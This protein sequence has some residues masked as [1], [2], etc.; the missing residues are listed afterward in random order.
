[1]DRNQRDIKYFNEK[2][3]NTF[4]VKPFTE[5]ATTP[6]G[7]VKLCC[8][9]EGIDTT[10]DPY[11]TK[12]FQEVFD[13]STQLIQARKDL[14]S[15]KKIKECNACW[16]D[17]A[18]GNMSMRIEHS[19]YLEETNPTIL[20]NIRDFGKTEVKSIDIKFGNKCNYACVMCAPDNS[21]LWGKEIDKNP[22]PEGL[23]PSGFSTALIE[24]PNDKYDEL[25]EI[26]KN[27]VRI[28]ST[29]GEPMLLDGFKTYIKKLVESGYAKNIVFTTVTNGTIDCTD[30]LPYMNQFKKFNMQWSVDGTGRVYDY[31]RWPGNFDRMRRIHEKLAVEIKKNNYNRIKI[32]MLPVIQLFNLQ[33]LGDMIQ[34]AEEIGIVDTVEFS[35][36]FHEPE[37][38]NTGVLPNDMFENILAKLDEQ[39]KPFKVNHSYENIK[40]ILQKEQ[41]RIK[42]KKELFQRT[43]KM[44]SWWE[45]TRKINIYDHI[46]TYKD[47]EKQY[48]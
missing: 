21:S 45:K 36:I 20:E 19:R 3:G 33:N 34:Y 14:L 17:E 22:L 11:F 4:C 46:E 2:Y 1:M 9:S 5:I 26:S 37:Y 43:K 7:G 30:L 42:N 13:S 41:R 28:K 18:V 44:V 47:L 6:R 27:V 31:V 15:G 23:Y 29:G 25:L 12:N 38:L 35:W 10:D 40:P 8:Q 32:E 16:K 39:V 48:K 24:F